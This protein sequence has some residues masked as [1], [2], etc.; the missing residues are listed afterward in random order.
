M[1]R[2]N[3]PDIRGIAFDADG[4]LWFEDLGRHSV[5]RRTK[6][7]GVDEIPIPGDAFPVA[8]AFCNSKAWIMA[9]AT[10]IQKAGDYGTSLYFVEDDI[11][12]LRLA[13]VWQS[14]GLSSLATLRC[15]YW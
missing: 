9:E 7:G 14:E 3:F 13:R 8:F 2:K 1:P 12:A 5:G 15:E 4:A 11:R 10:G 6:A